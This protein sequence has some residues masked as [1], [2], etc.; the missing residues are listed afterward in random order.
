[1]RNFIVPTLLLLLL[2]EVSSFTASP[3]ALVL[4]QESLR[5]NVS[6]SL[7]SVDDSSTNESGD[8]VTTPPD[9]SATIPA[10]VS[11]EE[12]SYPIDLPSPLLLATSMVLAITGTGKH[13]PFLTSWA[14]F[15]MYPQ[16]T[17]TFFLFFLGSAFDL[18]GGSPTL[19]FGTT[20][21]IAA[22]SIPSCLFLFYASILKATAETEADDKE[23]MKGR[24]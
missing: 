10:P 9:D 11:E 20:A 13:V 23:F 21:A 2:I 17:N 14:S 12:A 3:R 18:G 7:F 24:Y 19:G 15:Y 22:V 4:G 6:P 8:D 5:K 16:N 1:M